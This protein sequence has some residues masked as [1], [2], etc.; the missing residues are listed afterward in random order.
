ME[1]FETA[2]RHLH[3]DAQKYLGNTERFCE[4][5]TLF[6]SLHLPARTQD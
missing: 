2:S 5:M 1:T 3:A 6:A 4:V